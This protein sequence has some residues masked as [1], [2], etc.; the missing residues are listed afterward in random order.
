MMPYVKAHHVLVSPL[1]FS[2]ENITRISDRIRFMKTKHMVDKVKK[3][4]TESAISYDFR[5]L[6]LASGIEDEAYEIRAQTVDFS[7]STGMFNV[8]EVAKHCAEESLH[9][10]IDHTGLLKIVWSVPSA[11]RGIPEKA[12]RVIEKV[13]ADVIW[14]AFR[15][16]DFTYDLF[17]HPRHYMQGFGFDAAQNAF[18]SAVERLSKRY[19]K[20]AENYRLIHDWKSLFLLKRQVKT[21]EERLNSL[22]LHVPLDVFAKNVALVQLSDLERRLDLES[23]DCLVKDVVL[24]ELSD[25]V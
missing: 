21:Y 6:W 3:R 7:P 20:F 15:P 1:P 4:T 9:L 22:A 12:R 5:Y 10:S 2:S 8:E 19:P 25:E 14:R 17:H 16:R 11:W 18:I 24:W 13:V 23:I